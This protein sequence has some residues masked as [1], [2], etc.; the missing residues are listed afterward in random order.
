MLQAIPISFQGRG[1]DRLAW[2]ENPKGIFD[3][4]SAYGIAM[5][6]DTN[7]PFTANWIWKLATLPRI[8]VF[9]LWKCVHNSIGVKDFLVGREVGSD[10]QCA[11]CQGGAETILHA[12]RNYPRV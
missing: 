11:I 9:F 1:S 6:D 2:V 4:K 7:F 5:E 3:L 10:N 12:L 8:K